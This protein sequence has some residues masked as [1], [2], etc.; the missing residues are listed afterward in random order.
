M[1]QVAEILVPPRSHR[2]LERVECEVRAQMVGDLPPE[3]APGEQVHDESGVTQPE[4]VRTW[5]M[6]ATQRRFGAAASK[7]RSSRS[8]GL[9]AGSPGS[10]VGGRF[11]PGLASRIPSSRTSRSTVHRA[12]GIPWL[13][14]SSHIFRAP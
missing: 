14:S 8:D 4:N 5:V 10:V 13:L 2:H 3:N 12:T 9:S 1:D 6:S 11:R 7:H